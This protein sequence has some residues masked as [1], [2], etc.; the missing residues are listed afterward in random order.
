MGFKRRQV[1]SA[2]QLAGVEAM[3][4]RQLFSATLVQITIPTPPTTT[5]HPK[6]HK[7]VKPAVKPVVKPAVKHKPAAG[8]QHANIGYEIFA[9]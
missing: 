3:E 7:P 2:W 1:G 6:V 9:G 4:S 5:K 8:E